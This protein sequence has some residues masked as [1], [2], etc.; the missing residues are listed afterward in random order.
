VLDTYFVFLRTRVLIGALPL[1]DEARLIDE[2]REWLTRGAE[3]VA[4]YRM[5]MDRWGDWHNPWTS[6][7]SDAGNTPP[8]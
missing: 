7:P 5:Y 8:D 6:P 3:S 2:T 1:A 4:A